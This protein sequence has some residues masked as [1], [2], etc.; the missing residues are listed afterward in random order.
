VPTVTTTSLTTEDGHTLTADVATPV[1]DPVG[2]VAICHPHPLHG[3][4]RHH[5][6]VTAL[7][8]RATGAGMVAV[9]FD[10]RAEHDGGDRERLDLRAALDHLAEHTDRPLAAAGYSFGAVVALR[11]DHPRRVAVVAVAPPLGTMEAEPPTVPAL[12]LTPRHDQFC[13]PSVAAPIVGAWP[14]AEL[15][16]VESADHFLAGHAAAVADRSVAWLVE[17][18]AGD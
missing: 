6:V 15:D 1:G 8:E 12:V 5:P 3:G 10:F 13:D 14:M 11:T 7:F 4:D 17:H 18:L 16:I 2:G 9:R